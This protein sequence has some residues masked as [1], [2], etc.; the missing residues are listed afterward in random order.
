M[1]KN[2]VTPFSLGIKEIKI[3]E[4]YKKINEKNDILLSGF[5]VVKIYSL[6]FFVRS[7]HNLF[8]LTFDHSF[9]YI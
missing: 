8:I 6:Y 4:I 2:E 5:A 7:Q 1:L 9:H 3:H